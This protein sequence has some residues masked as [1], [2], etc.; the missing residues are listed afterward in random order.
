MYN[1]S[2]SWVTRHLVH[3]YKDDYTIICLDK[4]DPVASWNNILGLFA[5][6]N[7]HFIHAN[8]LDAETVRSALESYQVD[9]V[10]HFAASSHVQNSFS[11]SFAFTENNVLGTHRLLDAVRVY[12]KVKR[13]VH[14]STDEVYGETRGV[15]ASEAS[16]PLAPTNPY[17]A[18]KAAAEMYVMAYQ[19]SYG[20][21]AIIVRGNNVYGPCQ[22]PESM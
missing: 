3:Q 13:F 5:C 1:N 4:M 22:Y 15:L 18:S 19:K 10:M 9:C 7:F 11:E 17:A 12:G 8:I 20:L 14:V 2:G 6:P 21:P 16:T